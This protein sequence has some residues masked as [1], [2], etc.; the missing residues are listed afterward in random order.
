MLKSTY[1]ESA[2]ILEKTANGRALLAAIDC[3]EYDIKIA[4]RLLLEADDYLNTNNQTNIG[5]GSILHI[6]FHDIGSNL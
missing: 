4:K 2:D 6:K 3:L 5:H 1:E